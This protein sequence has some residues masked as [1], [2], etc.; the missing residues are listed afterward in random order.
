MNTG[1]LSLRYWFSHADQ[2]PQDPAACQPRFVYTSSSFAPGKSLS[3]KEY[4]AQDGTP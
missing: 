2:P 1:R 3:G 4:D